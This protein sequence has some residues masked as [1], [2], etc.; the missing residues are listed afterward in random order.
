[1]NDWFMVV[2]L[3]VLPL[4]SLLLA[5]VAALMFAG[6]LPQFLRWRAGELSPTEEEPSISVLIPA[7]N[8]AT[9]I[10]RTVNAVLANTGVVL[11][12]VVL[13][14][15][16]VD[17]TGELV[18]QI[19]DQDPRVRLI[20]SPELP[21]GWNGKQHACC[22]LAEA[23]QFDLLLFLDA[24]V[25][26]KP[27][28]LQQLTRRKA[29]YAETGPA[30]GKP[31][32]LLSAF[33]NQE[34]GSL[35]EKMLIPMMHYILLCYLPFSRMRSRTDPGYAAGC[36]QVFVTDREAYQRSGTHAAIRA[37]RH[38]GIHLPRIYRQNGMLTDCV[39]GAGLATCRM[40]H[41]AAQV[42][43]GMLK[44]AHEGIANWR[45]LVPFTILLAGASLLPY[46]T[47]GYALVQYA[48]GDHRISIW[49]AALVSVAAIFLSHLPRWVAAWKLPQSPTGAFLHPVAIGL[50]LTLQWCAFVMHLCGQ[51]I[52]W[53]GR[54][55]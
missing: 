25:R 44:N 53:R 41:G 31:I 54:D 38:D 39:D 7:R 35:S 8:E 5:S 15:D 55:S 22:R 48:A 3:W 4:L 6:N 16:S 11:E 50:F 33:P 9:G 45:L 37:T 29:Q 13:D 26:L 1:M 47:L 52:A 42:V 21:A 24:D 46:V 20:S 10:T 2:M 43:R 12:V 23:A 40:Y 30:K 34:T 27:T 19:A 28:A 36:G 32:A 17:G 18:Q 49:F 14:D 51:Q